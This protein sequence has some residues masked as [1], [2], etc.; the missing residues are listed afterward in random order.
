MR[1]CFI[2]NPFIINGLTMI[3][4]AWHLLC[5]K[6][7]RTCF[8]LMINTNQNPRYPQL[9]VVTL[10]IAAT[11]GMAAATGFAGNGT[12]LAWAVGILSMSIFLASFY[13]KP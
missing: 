5:T 12:V 2:F 13:L 10:A 1:G 8:V 3:G 7:M 4:A 9:R 6:K 11:A